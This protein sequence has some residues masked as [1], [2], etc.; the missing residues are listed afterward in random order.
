MYK[1]ID[2]IIRP[3]FNNWEGAIIED[4][5]TGKKYITNGIYKWEAR[6][7]RLETCT[8]VDNI[9]IDAFINRWNNHFNYCTLTLKKEKD[10]RWTKT[11]NLDI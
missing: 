4:L 2:Y 9:N 6:E 7:N 5:K 3:K 8:V 11:I 1:V 10:R